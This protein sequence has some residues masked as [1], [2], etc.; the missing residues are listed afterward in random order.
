MRIVR[1]DFVTIPEPAKQRDCLGIPQSGVAHEME[2]GS[3]AA[4]KPRKS[5]LSGNRCQNMAN[6]ERKP[7]AP[8]EAD[9]VSA[10]M[11]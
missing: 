9:D 11:I 4:S 6:S 1:G 5:A 3:H 2:Q 8:L 7:A 10:I